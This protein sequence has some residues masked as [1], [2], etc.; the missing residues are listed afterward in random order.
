MYS[1]NE[2]Y[3]SCLR[4]YFHM[5]IEELEREHS[6]IK[7]CDRESY[8]E[9]LYDDEA[10]KKG[11]DDILEKTRDNPVF[12]SLYTLAAGQF[13]SDDIGIGLCV[14]LSYD[15]FADFISIYENNQLTYSTDSYVSLKRKL[16]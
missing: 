3:R 15:Y 13:L 8:D 7:E 5:N 11:M 16:S 4:N 9:L 14:L 12:T 6:Y 2:E 1:N 10:I